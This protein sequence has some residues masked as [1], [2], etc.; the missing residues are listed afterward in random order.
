MPND[1]LT[2]K[3]RFSWAIQSV[4]IKNYSRLGFMGVQRNGRFLKGGLDL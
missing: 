1:A 3:V 4:T 2:K